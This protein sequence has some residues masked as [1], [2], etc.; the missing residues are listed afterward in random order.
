MYIEIME[1]PA[2]RVL[3]VLL[4]LL[5]IVAI[6]SYVTLGSPWLPLMFLLGGIVGPFMGLSYP[7]PILYK[8]VYFFTAAPLTEKEK[9]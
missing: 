6:Y 4:A 3:T 2:I 1:K 9:A 8:T 5:I 7:F